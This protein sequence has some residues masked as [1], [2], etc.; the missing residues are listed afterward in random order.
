[1]DRN[2]ALMIVK[3]ELTEKRYNHTLGVL[4]TA[5][6]LA[7]RYGVNCQKAELAAIFHDYAKFR[8]KDEMKTIIIEQNMPKD[9]LSFHHELW[10]APVGSYLVKKEVGIDDEDIL[11]AIKY[12][13]TGNKNMNTLDKVIF[14]ADYIEPGRDFPGVEK[15]RKLALENLDQAVIQS[16]KNTIQFLMDQGQPIYPDT[17][18]T[19]N[20]LMMKGK[21]RSSTE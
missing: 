16:L 2:E 11:Q 17:F 15:V 5:V 8:S 14:L 12:H 3:D 9:L 7:E 19:Y 21:G 13:T 1:M 4:E 20:S 18:E 10:H 6:K